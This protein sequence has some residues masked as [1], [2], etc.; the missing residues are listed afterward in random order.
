MFAGTEVFIQVAPDAEAANL[1]NEIAI[2]LSRFGW[3]PQ[4]IEELRSHFP[5]SQIR[6]GV[7]VS[8]PI[9]KAW[10]VEEPNQPWFAWSHAAEA[11]ADALTKA[12]LAVGDRR[13]LRYGFTNEPPS[14]AGTAQY[15]DPPLTGVY[16]Q[17]GAR[18]VAETV[19]WI[20]QGRPN[21]L[22]KLP[23]SGMPPK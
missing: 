2:V 9:G 11:L 17:V 16:L 7:N 20:K 10:T 12:G 4:S 18:P 19:V 23:A 5:T 3:K 8:Y 6:D 1:A 15:F 22:G 14:L 21:V 13:V